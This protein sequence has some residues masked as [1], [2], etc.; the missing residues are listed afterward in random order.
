M[1]EYILIGL[2]ITL[3]IAFNPVTSYLVGKVYQKKIM[4]ALTIQEKSTESVQDL[5][6]MLSIQR[7]LKM[8]EAKSSQL[9]YSS[10]VVGPSWGQVALMGLKSLFGGRLVSYDHILAYGR[11]RVILDLKQ[12]AKA[13]GFQAIVNLR[14]ETSTIGSMATTGGKNSGTSSL[15][16]CAYATG[17]QFE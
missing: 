12:Q 16:I 14:L 17:L 1:I 4:K 5:T 3:T 9:I 7:K 6:E 11:R 10:I 2:V 8:M 15:E 13:M